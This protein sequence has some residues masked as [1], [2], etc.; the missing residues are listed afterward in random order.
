MTSSAPKVTVFVQ[1]VVIGSVAAPQ[2]HGGNGSR[3][4]AMAQCFS[5]YIAGCGG[6]VLALRCVVSIAS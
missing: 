4:A 1:V 6:Q 5:G 3:T 2:S